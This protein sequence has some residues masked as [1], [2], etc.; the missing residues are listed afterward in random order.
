MPASTARISICCV[1]CLSILLI[2]AP[3]NARRPIVG[4]LPFAHDIPNVSDGLAELVWREMLNNGRFNVMDVNATE[5]LLEDSE[6]N[7]SAEA[8]TIDEAAL[9]LLTPE[10]D[11]LLMGR[12]L[13]FEIVDKESKLDLGGD[14]ADL[15]TLLG[16]HSKAAYIA[17]EIRLV[18]LCEPTESASF[19]VEGIE[20]KRGVRLDR[21]SH[22]WAGSID[23]LSDE[24]RLTSMGRATYKAAGELIYLLYERFPL[25]GTVL[26]VAGDSVVLDLDARSGIQTGDELTVVREHEITNSEGA[27]VWRSERRIG[28]VQVLEFQPGR[29]LCLILDGADQ[30]QEGDLGRPVLDRIYVPL[31]TDQP[32]D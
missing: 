24:F 26:A 30:I 17:L 16:G 6:W 11:Y 14:F 8:L 23:F 4:I 21:I 25:R 3:V 15:A 31:E 13:A 29:C 2:A 7:L 28:S 9:P 1:V 12:V 19:V 18:E 5:Q 22:G 20:S 32:E 10:L 27:V